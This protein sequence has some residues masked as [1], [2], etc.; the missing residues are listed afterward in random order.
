MT[1]GFDFQHTHGYPQWDSPRGYSQ[2]P[3]LR[4]VCNVPEHLAPSFDIFG[5]KCS[6]KKKYES[7]DI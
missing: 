1:P 2:Y 4:T 7:N 5:S 6:L 3:Q